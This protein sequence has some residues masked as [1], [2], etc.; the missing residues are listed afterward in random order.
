MPDTSRLLAFGIAEA[1]LRGR[2]RLA[3]MCDRVRSILIPDPRG[4]WVKALASRAIK[5]LPGPIPPLAAQLIPF[6]ERCDLVA[7]YCDDILT[8]DGRSFEFDLSQ[9]PRPIMRPITEA[10]STWNVRSLTTVNDVAEWLGFVR[11]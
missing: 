10:A 4:R 9:L 11:W 8:T 2:W 7:R 1:F 6:L 5:Q 3:E